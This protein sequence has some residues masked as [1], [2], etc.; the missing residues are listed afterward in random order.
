MVHGP[1]STVHINKLNR[2]KKEEEEDLPLTL[3]ILTVIFP[4]QQISTSTVETKTIISFY[5]SNPNIQFS[6][7][8]LILHFT[9]I[10]YIILP[11]SPELH[12]YA[13]CF[14]Y[15]HIYLKNLSSLYPI[16][17]HVGKI[18]SFKYFRQF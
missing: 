10:I 16:V 9:C 1:H 13:F 5:L 18:E 17:E 8:K 14:Y 6:R 11:F 2:K 12:C 15:F 7:C 4:P 3:I